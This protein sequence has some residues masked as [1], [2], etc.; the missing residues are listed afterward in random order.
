MK[1]ALFLALTVAAAASAHADLTPR[2]LDVITV[3]SGQPVTFF[4]SLLDRPATGLTARFRFVAPELPQTLA[5]LSYD[6]LEADLAYLCDTYAM[7]RIAAPVPSVIVI[8]LS[9]RETVFGS[10]E[11]DV[12]QVFEAYRPAGTVCEWEAF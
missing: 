4:E 3:P 6:E 8:S 10:I 12:A 1:V 7:P 5:A 2:E 11:Q 9:E